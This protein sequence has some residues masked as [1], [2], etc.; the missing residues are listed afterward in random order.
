MLVIE[1]STTGV[2]RA[3]TTGQQVH[4]SLLRS[5][6]TASVLQDKTRAQMILVRTVCMLQTERP[7]PNVKL[8]L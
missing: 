2:L 6:I 8:L 5:Q 7:I 3:N 1:Q 4:S